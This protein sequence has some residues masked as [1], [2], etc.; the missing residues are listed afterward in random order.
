MRKGKKSAIMI[1]EMK[2]KRLWGGKR[3]KLDFIW[4]IIEMDECGIEWNKIFWYFDIFIG[5]MQ[6]V[7]KTNDG[8]IK[9]KLSVGDKSAIQILSKNWS[10]RIGRSAR[11][12][13]RETRTCI[14]A[15]HWRTN[16]FGSWIP[17]SLSNYRHGKQNVGLQLTYRVHWSVHFLIY[18]GFPSS[19]YLRICNRT[20][21]L[22][23]LSARKPAIKEMKMWIGGDE[24][25]KGDGQLK[26]E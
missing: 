6:N 12:R 13:D 2:G 7:S 23:L 9:W 3:R 21:E 10:L 14:V 22:L 11:M 19:Y 5:R 24:N 1:R 4:V 8:W 26:Y 15:E 16:C 20:K 25:E 18:P 17:N